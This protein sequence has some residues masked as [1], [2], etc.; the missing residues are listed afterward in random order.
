T[1]PLNVEAMRKAFSELIARHEPLRSTL[2]VQAGGRQVVV[3]HP[4][5]QI[6]LDELD[7]SGL[8]PEAQ[9]QRAIMVLR[10]YGLRPFDLDWEPPI[11]LM[12]MKRSEREHELLL[13]VHNF[14]W[15]G[16]SFDLF[17]KDMSAVYGAFLEGKPSP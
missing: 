2:R 12:L 6:R 8:T 10:D 3:V 11:R 13:G 9:D 16:W 15:D 4:E 17:L 5:R 14:A 7:V 1:G